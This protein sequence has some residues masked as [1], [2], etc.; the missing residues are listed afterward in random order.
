LQRLVAERESSRL[1]S[2]LKLELSGGDIADG[3]S[4]EFAKYVLALA[5][6]AGR[7]VGRQACLVIGPE[8]EL[9]PNGARTAEAIAPH[10]K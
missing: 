4:L 7:D 5:N 9:K 1:E 6:T 10:Q 3:R 2:K 8:D